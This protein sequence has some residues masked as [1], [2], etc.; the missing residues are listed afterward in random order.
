MSMPT[1]ARRVALLSTS[2]LGLAAIVSA[3]SLGLAL[4]PTAASAQ[5]TC[6]SGTAVTGDGTNTVT[7]ASGTNN[8]GIVCS[9]TGTAAAVTLAGSATVSSAA[10][11]GGI[12]LTATGSSAINWTSTAGTV[13]GGAF[14]DGPL[15]GAQS[16]TGAITINAAG[17][18]ATAA[19]NTRAIRAEA[20][21]AGTVTVNTTGAISATNAAAGNT[22]GIEALS[23]GGD[24]T[25]NHTVTGANNIT[26]R[27]YGVYAQTSGAGDIDI[28]V[29]RPNNNTPVTATSSLT[30]GAGIYA[31][32]GTGT[33]TINGRGV[34][35]VGTGVLID[36]GGDIDF[37]GSGSGNY[38]IDILNVAAGR[39][40]TLN[41][42]GTVGTT[43]TVAAVRA[44][45]AG[46]V[47]VNITGAQAAMNFD[48]TGMAAPVEV[49]VVGGGAWRPTAN[50]STVVPTGNFSLVIEA[51][52]ALIAG[53]QVGSGGAANTTLEPTTVLTFADPAFS[54]DNRGF[55]IVGPDSTSTNWDPALLE[56]ELR[57]VGLS[58]F[59][60]SGTIQLGGLGYPR[61]ALPGLVT[62]Q[63]ASAGLTDRWYDDMLTFQDGTW[64]GEGGRVMFDADLNRTQTNCTRDPVTYDFG[65]ADCLRI[66][67]STI[68]GVT[69]IYVNQILGGDRGRLT[70]QMMDEGI[71]LIETPGSTVTAENFA[72]DSTLDGYNPATATLDKGLFQYALLFDEGASQFKLFPTLSGAAYELPMAA[73]AAHNLW[74][75][76]TGSW[77][78]RQADLRGS[79]PEAVGGGIWLRASGEQTDRTISNASTLGGLPFSVDSTHRADT[80]AV[81]GGLDIFSGSDGNIGYVVGV[82]AGYAHTDVKYDTSGNTQAMDAWT[83]GIYGGLVVGQLFVDAVVNANNVIIDTDAPGFGLLPEGTIYSSRMISLG[84]QVEAGWRM[85]FDGG[86]FAEPLASVSY[87]R[88]TMEDLDIKPDDFS[89]PGLAVSFEDPS[90]LRAGVGGRVGLDRDFGVVR[91][92]FSLLGR[93]WND[94]E[95]QNTAVIHNL[96]FP[97][98]PDIRVTDDF[99]GITSEVALGVSVYSAGGAVS[100]FVNLGGRFGDDYEAK[101]GSVGVRVAW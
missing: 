18:S 37:T 79:M 21:G 29:L 76:S 77:L 10:P 8:P 32:T 71:V 68:E 73:T 25:V 55:I 65:A 44:A 19:T 13:T 4:T 15:I 69:Y 16:Q 62:I 48:F 97:T 23:G 28:T 39:T 9:Y 83:G 49:K 7:I 35:G 63:G 89:R 78:N 96:A 66:V 5:A 91:S 81:N 45:G 12:D 14:V 33:V 50:A 61:Q 17:V 100:G 56:A 70:Q 60:N 51:G 1:T 30:G 43:G 99:S 72:L 88:S 52:G 47:L 86:F 75:V 82:T 59:R 11:G 57:I 22:I 53:A 94:L 41:L 3:A 85:L 2:S 101:T 67:D 58:E 93:V 46:E 36:T 27:L 92:Q 64:I 87:V 84:G 24:V 80:Y 34:G 54:I 90:S 74:R 98:D 6:T 26:G 42:T 20:T 31:R 38:G 40:A 95:G